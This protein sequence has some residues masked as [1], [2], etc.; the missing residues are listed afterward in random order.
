[1]KI[2]ILADMEGISG[3]RRIEQVSTAGGGEPYEEGRRLMIAEVNATVA[4]CFDAGADEVIACDTHA[5]GGQLRMAEMDDRAEYETPGS[6]RLMPSLDASFDGVILLGHHAMAGTTTAFLDHT[7]SSSSWFEYRLNDRPMGEI[8]IEAAWAGH[9]DVPVILVTG[10]AATAREAV[11]TLGSVETAVVKQAV[12]RNRARCLS[13]PEAHRLIAEAVQRAIGRISDL[14]AF[15]P[16][17]P[18]TIQ[19]TLCRTDQCE[20]KA[21]TPGT[22]RVDGRTVRRP[23]TTMLDVVRW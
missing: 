4:A 16:A 21:F 19:L 12:A 14:A 15:K 9:Y 7:M 13:L 10:D 1:M 11:D 22:Q 2:Y 18:A 8:G 17:L 3:I 5:G 20:E 6:G 23:I